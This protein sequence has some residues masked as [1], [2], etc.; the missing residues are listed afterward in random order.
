M[1]D[2]VGVTTEDTESTK[3][4]GRSRRLQPSSS[5]PHAYG[6]GFG[7]ATNTWDGE[8]L[9]LARSDC[10]ESSLKTQRPK[11]KRKMGKNHERHGRH[12]RRAAR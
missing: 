12:E 7:K 6:L 10:V 3:R 5:Y 1:K 9:T 2:E 8:D 4:G 11:G